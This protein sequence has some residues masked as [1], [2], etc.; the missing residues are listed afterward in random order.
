MGKVMPYKGVWP[1]LHETV[2]MTDGTFVIG[3]VHIGAYSSIWFNAVVRGADERSNKRTRDTTETPFAD[4]K[5]LPSCFIR[6]L[7][8]F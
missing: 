8:L 1:Q 4:K 6:H 5:Y 2:F 3:D 7:L